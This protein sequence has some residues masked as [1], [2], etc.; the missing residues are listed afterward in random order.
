METKPLEPIVSGSPSKMVVFSR[1]GAETMY[2]AS[3]RIH[4]YPFVAATSITLPP[5][6]GT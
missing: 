2:V 4:R 5:G 3:G 1:G 6:W